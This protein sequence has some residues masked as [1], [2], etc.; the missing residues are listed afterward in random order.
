MQV[1][2][3]STPECVQC[4][5]TAQELEKLGIE[6]LVIDLSES[7]AALEW[8]REHDF[9]QAPVLVV[10]DMASN[11]F[12]AWTGFRPDRIKALGDRISGGAH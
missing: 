6:Y 8:C 10:G 1:T 4:R 7:D 2:M 5:M 11:D 3:L 9:R 12:D